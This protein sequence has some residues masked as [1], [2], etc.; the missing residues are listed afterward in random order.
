M[1][2]KCVECGNE[3]VAVAGGNSYC[4]SCLEQN[5]TIYWGENWEKEFEKYNKEEK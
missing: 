4:Q 3:A 2:L 5:K 1:S